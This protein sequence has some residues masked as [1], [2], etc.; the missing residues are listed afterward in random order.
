MLLTLLYERASKMKRAIAKA[1]KGILG[2]RLYSKLLKLR[3]KGLLISLK[4]GLDLGSPLT[5]PEIG[6]YHQ[7]DKYNESHSFAG[8]SYLHIYERYLNELRDEDISVLEIGV[9]D[10]ASLRMWKTYFRNAHIYGIDIDPRC[11][12][13]EEERIHV[14][15]GSQDNAKFLDNCFGGDKKFD[16]IIDD[17]S[18]I[19][20]LTIAS[21]NNLFEKRLKP[22]GYYIIED[23][24]CSYMK[25]QEEHN[26]LDN[27][28]G[29]KYNDPGQ[30]FDNN[31]ADMDS[32]FSQHI[33]ELDYAKGDI[34]FIHFWA[35]TC[36]MQKVFG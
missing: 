6:R 20:S 7:T 5:L 9:R 12:S 26:V 17:G 19:N 18:H 35:M 33:K 22:G 15:I 2:E 3:N 25:L 11:K 4:K 14:E 30:S 32:F 16:V 29:M 23:L 34:L 8:M 21:F 24:Q 28:P 36:V 31:R 27:W 10:G 1:V 13:S